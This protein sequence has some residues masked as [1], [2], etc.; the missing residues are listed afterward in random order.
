M[1]K[2]KPS[3]LWTNTTTITLAFFTNMTQI[4]TPYTVLK[5]SFHFQA[6]H[7]QAVLEED[8]DEVHLALRMHSLFP[9]YGSL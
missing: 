3:I 9:L 8:T 1:V 7:L 2:R 6:F 4:Y 5:I